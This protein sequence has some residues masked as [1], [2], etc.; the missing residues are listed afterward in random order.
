MYNVIG[1]QRGCRAVKFD[2][3][4]NLISS[5][6]TILVIILRYIRLHIKPKTLLLLQSINFVFVDQTNVYNIVTNNALT[7]ND[8]LNSIHNRKAQKGLRSRWV[9][10]HM[11]HTII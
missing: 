10:L 5:V 11:Y 1:A 3:C 2:Y 7:N 6:H 9:G 8:T 4:N